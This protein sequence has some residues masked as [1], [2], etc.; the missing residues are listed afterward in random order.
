VKAE[1]T[2]NEAST[3]DVRLPE[4]AFGIQAQLFN[5]A[6]TGVPRRAAVVTE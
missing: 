5:P 3:T 6:P 1:V 4:I 2:E